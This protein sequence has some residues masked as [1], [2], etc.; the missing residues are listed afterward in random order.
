LITRLA[1]TA[2]AA[3]ALLLA[4]GI[5][6]AQA[7]ASSGAA[8]ARILNIG[9]CTTEGEAASCSVQGDISHPRSISVQ[10]WGNPTQRILVTWGD[11]CAA[12]FTSGDRSGQFT[13]TAGPHR[14]VTRPVPLAAGHSGKCTPDVLVSLDGSGSLHVYLRGRH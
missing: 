10:V 4:G 12:G 7:T 5:T 3:A 11:L 9:N 1:L 6:A 2:T 13:V 14:K 8:T